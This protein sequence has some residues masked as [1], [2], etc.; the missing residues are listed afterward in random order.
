MIIVYGDSV[1]CLTCAILKV[2]L[3]DSRLPFR[4]YEMSKDYLIE[5][6]KEIYPNFSEVPFI[7]KDGKEISLVEL[8]K[9]VYGKS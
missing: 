7:I 8:E 1:N 5:E 6:V 9:E 3:K 2:V 4:F